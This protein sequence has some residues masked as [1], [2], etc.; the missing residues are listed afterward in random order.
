[1][2]CVKGATSPHDF[3]TDPIKFVTG[4]VWGPDWLTADDTTLGSDNGIGACMALAILDMPA[5]SPLPPVEALFTV[6]EETGLTGVQKLD[7]SIVE[8]RTLINL[9]T[10]QWGEICVGCAGNGTSE[11]HLPLQRTQPALSN[12]VQMD[13]EV[14][15]TKKNLH[16]NSANIPNAWI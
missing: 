10:E 13:I 5:D 6:D 15:E 7:P 14:C 4:G 11:I 9:D 2:V 8:G 3:D 12:G 16:V 1:M